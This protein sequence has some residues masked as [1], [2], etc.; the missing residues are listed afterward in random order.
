MSKPMIVTLPFVLLLLDFWPLGRAKLTDRPGL[1]KLVLEKIPL[2][3]LAAA[4]SVLT[5]LVQSAGGATRAIPAPLLLRIQ[6]AIE[7]Y[8]LYL[9]QMLWPARLAILYPFP[10]EIPLWETLG[11][12]ALLIAITIVVLK[13]ARRFPYLPIG[14]LWYLGTL[15]PVIGF[16]HVGYQAR[17][18]RYTYIPLIGIG[19][20]LAWGAADLFRRSPVVLASAAGI[21]LFACLLITRAQ[22]ETWID[23]AT[24]FG[25]AVAVTSDNYIAHNNVCYALAA[26]GQLSEAAP[27][28]QQAI[29]IK[30]DYN[31]A[32][33]NLGDIYRLQGR[34]DDSIAE[35][36][37][38]IRL[39]PSDLIALANLANVLARQGKLEESAGKYREAL[40]VSPSHAVARIGLAR[41]L[42]Q[43]DRRDE[44]LALLQE[45]VRI[46]PDYAAAHAQL[47]ILLGSLGRPQEALEALTESIRLNPNDA[48]AHYN[49]GV[50][51]SGRAASMKP[52]AS[53]SGRLRSTPAT[54]KPTLSS[55]TAW[56]ALAA[57][58]KP[59]R[60][61]RRR[62]S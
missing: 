62:W 57:S 23:G 35:S 29:R 33:T 15:V 50:T 60:T 53:F 55:A 8:V 51:L 47:G 30:P 24:L 19:I 38:A 9:V 56:P 61:F 39:N 11:A 26:Q 6:N 1:R 52:S 43:L 44:A 31:S 49:L 40:R 58:A 27:H 46:H 25:H 36:R 21:A 54:R 42:A 17:A 14:W 12:A 28:C 4:G 45:T 2:F 59:S 20:L 37:E 41:V 13:A 34:L 10:T 5:Y 3:V 18:D 7:S 32:H 16:I 48:P 22:V